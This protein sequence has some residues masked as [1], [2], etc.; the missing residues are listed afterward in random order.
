MCGLIN[1]HARTDRRVFA[2][3]TILFTLTVKAVLGCVSIFA[4]LRQFAVEVKTVSNIECVAIVL[5]V[6]ARITDFFVNS[7]ELRQRKIR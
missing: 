6:D 5:D 3:I 2:S 1:K 7:H 4:L